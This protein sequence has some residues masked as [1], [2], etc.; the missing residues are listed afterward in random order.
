MTPSCKSPIRYIEVRYIEVLFHTFY[1]NFGRDVEYR[2]LVISRTSLNRGSFNRGST[3]LELSI[4]LTFLI[5]VSVWHYPYGLN[6]SHCIVR[7]R[8]TAINTVTRIFFSRSRLESNRAWAGSFT[9]ICRNET[10]GTIAKAEASFADGSGI[11]L[12]IIFAEIIANII[13]VLGIISF[14]FRRFVQLEAAFVQKKLLPEI[15]REAN[16]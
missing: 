2:S 1:C 4:C 7:Q 5:E 6:H 10:R 9:L 8:T 11:I 14:V 16:I 3:V 12:S 15:I 13:V